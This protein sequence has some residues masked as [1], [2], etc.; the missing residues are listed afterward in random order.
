MLGKWIDPDIMQLC[1]R[2]ART[3]LTTAEREYREQ[4]EIG[5]GRFVQV[6]Q[7]GAWLGSGLLRRAALLN[8]VANTFFADGYRG[9]AFN[10]ARLH[11]G[12]PPPVRPPAGADA[13][14]RGSR[15]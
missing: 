7:R 11:G 14:V 12:R 10:M 5:K 3:G 15:H 13:A 4:W 8:T 6:Q 1:W 2:T 9:A